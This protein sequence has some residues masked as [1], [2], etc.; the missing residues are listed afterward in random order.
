MVVIQTPVRHATLDT[1]AHRRIY[2]VCKIICAFSLSITKTRIM[3]KERRMSTWSRKMM[4]VQ[5]GCV[6][7]CSQF[8]IGNLET[9]LLAA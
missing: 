2:G 4:S 1:V 7:R 5:Y 8:R 3:E 9:K 6:Q